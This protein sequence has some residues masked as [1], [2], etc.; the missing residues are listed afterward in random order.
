MITDNVKVV[1]VVLTLLNVAGTSF[2]QNNESTYREK[3]EVKVEKLGPEVNSNFD[4]YAA[5][6]RA[7]GSEMFFTSRR[8]YSEK[9]KKKDRESNEHIYKV[10][11]DHKTDKWSGLQPLPESINLP[12]RHA[13]NLALSNDGQRLFLYRDDQQGNGDIFES[14]LNGKRWSEPKSVGEPVN[15]KH[16]ESSAS[17]TPDGRALFF[18]SDRP[19]GEGGRDIWICHKKSD[20]SWG[21]AY[22]IGTE[23]N[24]PKDEEGVFIHPDGKTIYFS[25]NGHEGE[26]DYD[27]FKSVFEGGKWQKPVN[28]GKE[29]NTPGPDLFYVE[30]ASGRIAYY[31]S[32]VKGKDDKDVFR[33]EYVEEK[34]D[35]GPSLTMIKGVV[36]DRETGKPIEAKIEITDN[37]TEK[38]IADY[39]S[40]NSTGKY[41]FSLPAGKDYGINVSAPG[42]LFYS[43][44]IPIPDSS[45]FEEIE[46]NIELDKMK[47]GE[48]VVLR[49][50][51]FDYGKSSLKKES[52]A[53]LKRVIKMLRQHE[54]MVIEIA[55]HTDNKGGDE[56]NLN[57]SR[58]RAK[59]V[60]G[61]LINKGVNKE[62]LEYEG[63]GEQKPIATNETEEGR[64]FNRRVSFKIVK[65]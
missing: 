57:L 45:K 41:L 44:H 3:A 8:P 24:T 15:S 35:A 25:S 43:E 29:I 59:A 21:K 64:K 53:E 60:V 65:Y 14:I 11:Y 18:V 7:D 19:G 52:E 1:G 10:K 49:N 22:N 61:H 37:S 2:S 50:I 27:I 17:L 20:D 26:G 33:I 47:V 63:Y 16:H 9:E 54:N 28:L 6:I 31:S 56:Y 38:V 62:R 51:F 39:V 42:Y 46:K 32:S 23:I 48:E 40:N 55:G 30:E 5:V 34:D 13:S 4:D 58:E 36:T 12:G